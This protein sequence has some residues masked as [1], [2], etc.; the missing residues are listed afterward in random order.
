MKTRLLVLALA[1]CMIATP[2]KADLYGFGLINLSSSFDGSSSF[3]TVGWANTFG[4][5]YRSLAGGG[6]A[7]AVFDAGSWGTG[8]ESLSIQMTISSITS[9]TAFGSGTISVTDVDGGTL[10]ANVSGTW[11]YGGGIPMFTGALDTVTFTP[12]T[13]TFD[14][15]SGDSVS[16]VF[17]NN[18][19]PWVGAI[20]QLTTSGTWFTSGSYANKTGGS[21]DASVVP[22]PAAIVLGILGLG[23]AGLKLRKYA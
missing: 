12:V 7:T 11:D 14:G 15:H 3:S 22:V 23:V 17:P 16:M 19:Q 21:I 2:A 18:P 9:A 20:V 6:T 10:L 5:L 13:S 8:S 1:V 4:G